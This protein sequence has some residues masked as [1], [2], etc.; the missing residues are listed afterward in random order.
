MKK[1]QIWKILA[2]IIIQA[3]KSEKIRT[4]Q[5]QPITGTK[6]I[7]TVVIP[8]PSTITVIAL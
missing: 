5:N 2:I 3:K 1:Q 7:D 6:S 4:L 8:L